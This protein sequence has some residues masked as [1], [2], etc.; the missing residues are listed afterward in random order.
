MTIRELLEEKYIKG[1]YDDYE[2]YK[3]TDKDHRIHTDFIKFLNDTDN[4]GFISLDKLNDM[5]VCDYQLM[6]EEDYNNT[7]NANCDNANFEEWYG[8]K[9]A[10][11][12]IIVLHEN[13]EV[14]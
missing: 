3:Y 6:D 2:I 10:I 14:I 9:N 5:N 8:N 4:N 1:H 12:L 7:I 11:V 13:Y